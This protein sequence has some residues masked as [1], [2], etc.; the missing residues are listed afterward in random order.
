MRAR[1]S[2]FATDRLDY[3][4]ATW[5]PDTRPVDLWPAPEV[6]WVGLEVLKTV[7]GG[8]DHDSGTVEFRAHFRA[9]GRSRVMH[10]T[11]RF[12]RRATRWVYVDAVIA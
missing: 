3:V 1:Y 6:R 4:L 10:E 7:E 8:V 9:S 5:H 12:Q 2:A 11:S